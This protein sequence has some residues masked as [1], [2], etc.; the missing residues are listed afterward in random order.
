VPVLVDPGRAELEA[1]LTARTPLAFVLTN[2]RSLPEARAVRL[3]TRLGN[4][5]ARA[6]RATGRPVS[7][8]SRSD[9]TLRGHFPAEV[10]ALSA[11]AGVPEAPVLLMPYLGEAGRLT[12]GDVHYV[13]R[14]GV[15]IPVAETEY[16]RDAAFAYTESALARWAAAR[17]AAGGGSR[18]IASIGLDAIRLGGPDAVAAALRALPD[19]AVCVV[20]AADDRDAEV[21][22]AAVVDVEG[23]RAIVGRTAAGYVRARGGQARAPDLAPGELPVGPGPGLVVVGSHVPM[24]TRQLERLLADPPLRLELVELPAT[25][26]V[27]DGR[28]AGRARDAGTARVEALLKAGMTP[29]VATSRERLEPTAADPTGLALGAR[30][31]RMLVG[32]VARS[33]R[34]PAWVLAKGGITS[35]DVATDGL[36]AR[37]ATV[38]GQLLPGVP[39]WRA[40]PPGRRPILLVVFPG[41]VGDA[42]SLRAAVAKLAEAGLSR[43][44]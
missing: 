2:S 44:T 13:V 15:P 3:A 6:S 35:S 28:A 23:E 40:R 19:H 7:L 16:A 1:M 21:V 10:D 25:A 38:L 5:I 24:T 36:G 12:I 41:N 27:S 34:R 20:N 9:S 18:P 42:D 31:S 8:V 43:R 39:A 32:V 22:A 29:V 30:V 17:V 26:A 14:E 33:R 37:S 4:L 11:A